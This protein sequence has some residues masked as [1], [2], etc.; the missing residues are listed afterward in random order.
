MAV[1]R[2]AFIGNSLKLLMPN[3]TAGAHPKPRKLHLL[4]PE[5]RLRSRK[6]RAVWD[7]L[8]E[9]I[10]THPYWDLRVEDLVQVDSS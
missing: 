1:E 2:N 4:S 9:I 5:N 6:V 10:G 8:A 3:W 7:A